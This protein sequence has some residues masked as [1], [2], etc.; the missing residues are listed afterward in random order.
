MKRFLSIVFILAIS[1]T[2]VACG[3]NYDKE[4][5][6]VSKLKNSQIEKAKLSNVNKFQRDKSN[7]Y[8]YDNGA[9][10]VLKYHFT[11]N[12]SSVSYALYRKDETAGK[13]EEDYNAK[14]KKFMKENKPDYK[15][16]N[17]KE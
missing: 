9:V 10:I 16:E 8:V 7:I 5:E 11:K 15:E 1:I 3:K 14:P 6:E 4:I 17:L 2:L 12:S 13:Y